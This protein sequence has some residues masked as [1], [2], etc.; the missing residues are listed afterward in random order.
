MTDAEAIKLE[1]QGKK[2]SDGIRAKTRD[3]SERERVSQAWGKLFNV[4]GCIA[5]HGELNMCSRMLLAKIA[6]QT[7]AS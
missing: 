1:E 2:T 7:Y 4:T 6:R 5:R 3:E